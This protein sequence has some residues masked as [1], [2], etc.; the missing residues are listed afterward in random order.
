MITNFFIAC[1]EWG[2]TTSGTLDDGKP[3]EVWAKIND[4]TGI[5][6]L[7]PVKTLIDNVYVYT[8]ETVFYTKNLI[9]LKS[10]IK[11]KDNYYELASEPNDVMNRGHHY[12]MR[13][14]HVSF[15]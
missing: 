2:Y 8:D 5:M 10:R 15:I 13:C 11:Y 12:E 6:K 1:E 7:K 14:S 3:N 4:I 9:D